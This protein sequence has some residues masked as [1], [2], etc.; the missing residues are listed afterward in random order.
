LKSSHEED[1]MTTHIGDLVPAKATRRSYWSAGGVYNFL[2]TGEETGGAYFTFE[3]IEGP[4]A[5][6]PPHI[7][8]REQESF[9]IVD[10]RCTFYVGDQVIHAT[11]GDFVTV[12]RDVAHCFRNETEDLLRMVVTL[13]PSGME[14][15]FEEVLDPVDDPTA[16]PPSL[17]PEMIQRMLAAASKHGLEILPPAPDAHATAA[18]EPI[19]GSHREPAAADRFV[20]DLFQAVDSLDAK[21]F[22]AAFAEGGSFRFGNAA[23]AIGRQQIEEH[24]AGFFSMIGGLRHDIQ[25]VWSGAWEGG[26]VKSVEAM[27]TY[28]RT[29]GT[30][31]PPIPATSTLRTRAGLIEDFRIFAD[32][33]PLFAS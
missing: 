11:A 24:V 31:T 8:H 1:I 23:P 18:P 6:P 20:T 28:L 22:T 25:G 21:A 14:H 5:G 15:F 27:V 2:A 4:G 7:H 13:V 29:D 3:A 32:I 10:G 33:S 26:E 19:E 17:S 30:A 12:P 9:Y 16:A